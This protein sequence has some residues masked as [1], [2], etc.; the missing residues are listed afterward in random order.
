MV[1]GLLAWAAPASAATFCVSA[2]GCTGTTQPDLQAALDAAEANSESDR[3]EIGPGTFVAPATGFVYEEPDEHDLDLVGA[4]AGVTILDPAPSVTASDDFYD[5]LGVAADDTLIS[6]LTV[7]R[8]TSPGF[9]RF[10]LNMGGD[11]NTVEDVSLADEAP[12]RQSDQLLIV[13][14]DSI[15]LRRVE[16]AASSDAILVSNG[17]ARIEDSRLAGRR[18][19]FGQNADLTVVRSNLTSIGGTDAAG[20]LASGG[21]SRVESSLIRLAGTPASGVEVAAPAGTNGALVLDG[22]TIVGGG[23]G[24]TGGRAR[25][26]ISGSSTAAL[27]VRNSIVRNMER[28]FETFDGTTVP[29]VTVSHSDYRFAAVAGAVTRGPGNLDDVN[30]LFVDPVSGD[31]RL[32]AASPLIDAGDP[33]ATS[34]GLASATDLAGLPRVVEGRGTGG[35]AIDMGAHEYAREAPAAAASADPLAARA[36]QPIAFRGEGGDPD[37]T[38]ALTFTWQFD[39]GATE[40]GRDVTHAFLTGGTH[41]ATLTVTDSTGLSATASVDVEVAPFPGAALLT[42]SARPDGRRFVRLRVE[43]PAVASEACAGRLRLLRAGGQVAA[44]RFELPSG[45]RQA[46]NI[47][48]TKAAQ[49]RLRRR[50]PFTADAVVASADATGAAAEQSFRLRLRRPR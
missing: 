27:I 7:R 33:A 29:S 24:H 48:L 32:L 42:R 12:P 11:R 15:V 13:G 41:R 38:D 10:G 34:S 49:R 37:R 44:K 5:T 20:I 3:I 17:S 1:L 28:A 19:I 26:P 47:R 43:C 36:G 4:G 18:A 23:A 9:D 45:A 2:P 6:D 8:D 39:D 21:T 25:G 16:A 50:G 46:M 30:P 31:F 40:N 35:P 22:V 14:G